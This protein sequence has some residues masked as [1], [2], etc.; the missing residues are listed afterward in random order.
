MADGMNLGRPEPNGANLDYATSDAWRQM[1]TTTRAELAAAA[2][3]AQMNSGGNR[4]RNV[5]ENNGGN[6]TVS[7]RW[8]TYPELEVVHETTN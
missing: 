1:N 6:H 8:K 5:A 7:N 2:A 4:G 3:L